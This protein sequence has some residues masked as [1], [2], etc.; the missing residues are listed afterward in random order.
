MTETKGFFDYFPNIQLLDELKELLEAQP[1][2]NAVYY[3]KKETVL[4]VLKLSHQLYK[5][6]L[7]LQPQ[8]V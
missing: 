6:Y 2:E 8:Y 7:G 5:N 1:V 3:K 4:Q